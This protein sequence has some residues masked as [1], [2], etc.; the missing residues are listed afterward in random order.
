PPR[1]LLILTENWTMRPPP[2]V[3]DLVAFAVE[4]ERAGIEGV[5]VSEHIDLGPA[6]NAPGVP[7]NPRDYALPG[8]QDPAPPWPSPVVLLSAI[9]AA[10]R[11]L[12]LPAG[13]PPP[14]LAPPPP[15]PQGP[16]PPR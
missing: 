10:T 6:A 7:A 16:A 12:R 5:M 15:P 4:A 2:D 14:P 11:R 8:N 9:A 13:A 3:G 1:L